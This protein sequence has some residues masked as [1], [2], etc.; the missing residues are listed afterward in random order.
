MICDKCN[1]IGYWESPDKKIKQWCLKC[2]G[3][4][5]LDWIE[6]IFGVDIDQK[7]ER[8][9]ADNMKK[10]EEMNNKMD[11]QYEEFKK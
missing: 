5:E 11:K 6:E 9:R 1:G 4:K 10:R 3:E 8:E 2:K 7:L